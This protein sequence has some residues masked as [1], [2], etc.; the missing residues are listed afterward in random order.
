MHNE[1]TTSV[2]LSKEVRI[3]LV[4]SGGISLVVYMHGV[5]MELLRLV[6]APYHP[7]KREDPGDEWFLPKPTC[8][9]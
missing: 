3:A 8:K 5:V 2:D 1:N 7:T 6:Q 9:N 4:V